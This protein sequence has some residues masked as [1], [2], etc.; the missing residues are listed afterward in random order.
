MQG[1]LG[2]T[3][4]CPPRRSAADS[5]QARARARAPCRPVGMPRGEGGCALLTPRVEDVSKCGRRMRIAHFWQCHPSFLRKRKKARCEQSR[6][7]RSPHA[8]LRPRPPILAPKRLAR[9]NKSCCA[10]RPRHAGALEKALGSCGRTG[11]GGSA[12]RQRRG[13]KLSCTRKLGRASPR[14]RNALTARGCPCL[15]AARY[16]LAE[17]ALSLRTPPRP[18]S[19]RNPS[20]T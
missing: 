6:V 15:A 11:R 12:W 17:A 8:R 1:A 4:P 7:V 19:R 13:A 3:G 18:C 14:R 9:V 10:G 16:H 20:D 5:S 2:W